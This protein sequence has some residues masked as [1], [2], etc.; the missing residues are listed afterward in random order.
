VSER[1]RRA[2]L[3]AILALASVCAAPALADP[4]D[5]PWYLAGADQPRVGFAD[6][7]AP[8]LPDDDALRSELVPAA[9]AAR[10]GDLRRALT[11]LPRAASLPEP[12]AADAVA[13]L[14]AM[15]EARLATGRELHE[16]RSELRQRLR[17]VEDG[18]L[19]LCAR[20]E[21]ARLALRAGRAIDAIGALAIA[22]RTLGAVERARPARAQRLAFLRAEALWMLGR[23]AEALDA[24]R[25]LAASARPRVAWVARMRALLAAPER[26][27]RDVAPLL[28]RG[29][30]LGV[31]LDVWAA[32]AGEV[33][34]ESQ[35]FGEALHWYTRA[36]KVS[37]GD[38]LAT[39]RRADALALDG[40]AALA[41]RILERLER[42]SEQPVVREIASIR[43]ARTPRGDEARSRE[44][45]E[46]ASR[47][48]TPRVAALALSELVRLELAASRPEQALLAVSRLR[49][50]APR[51]GVPQL[52]ELTD[53]AVRLAAE[54]AE[55]C[56]TVVRRLAGGRDPW[57]RSVRSPEPL[58][59]LGDCASDL[60]LSS[61]AVD[62][63]RALGRRF[64]DRLRPEL[65]LRI[66]DASWELG[67]RSVVDSMLAAQE[68][69]A[70]E[71]D[72]DFAARAPWMRLRAELALADGEPVRALELLQ[73][74]AVS[75]ETPARERARVTI[76]L[77][78]LPAQADTRGEITRALEAMLRWDRDLSPEQAGTAWL[79]LADLRRAADRRAA[80]RRAYE[81]ATELLPPGDARGRSLHALAATSSTRE[82]REAV[83]AR[84]ARK[85]A[86]GPWSDL[87]KSELR[88]SHLRH[89]IDRREARAR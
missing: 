1:G 74:L 40:R 20:L 82:E 76:M 86:V 46:R 67:E 30:R 63:Y 87:A 53:A 50:L 60:G 34:W 8:C 47:S 66:A 52:D 54:T 44:R 3:R 45:L 10:E 22:E 88:L 64:P 24:H 55:D 38:E 69:D 80:A 48:Q 62:V 28:E 84:L 57:L 83:L 70:S 89:L 6:V 78:K 49:T 26:H 13:L 41:R 9:A 15:L 42:R 2:R 23:R 58:L 19:R 21:L 77:T 71:H 16:T 12:A 65:A 43:L 33:A 25:A 17:E 35:R 39:L 61:T 7:L 18:E 11:R 79:R 4:N 31:D 14:E 72:D 27:W 51:G 75:S 29:A 32:A 36:E 68:L 5:G 85:D 81:R 56:I 73:Q 37:G 59:R